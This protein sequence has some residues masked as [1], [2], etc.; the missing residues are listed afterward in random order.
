M[1][2]ALDRIPDDELQ[3]VLNQ[4]ASC[5]RIKAEAGDAE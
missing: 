5:V 4:L 1:G 3:R 2:R